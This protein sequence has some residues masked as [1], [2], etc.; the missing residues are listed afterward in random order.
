MNPGPIRVGVVCD[1]LEERWP[2]MDLVAEMILEHLAK[3]PAG[4]VV[5]ERI[6]PPWR[7]RFT[8]LPAVG[9]KGVARNA[10]RVF[11]RYLNYPRQLRTIAASGHYDLFHLVDHSYAQLLLAL[12]PGRAVV[13]CHD[14][15]TFR[16]L[17]EPENE[18]RPRWFRAL[19]QRTLTG[20]QNAAAVACDS[21]ATKS[22]ILRHGLLPEETLRV[23]YLSVHPECSHEPNPDHDRA[24]T[25]LLG[26]LDPD[27]P[28]EI[29]HVGSNI[30]RKRIDVLLNVFAGIRRAIPA[31]RL[32]KV[33]GRFTPEQQALAESL[34][35]VEAITIIPYFDP[36]SSSQRATLAAVYRRA[37]LAMQTSDAEGFGLPVA[38]AMACGTTV[39]AS[40]LPVLREVGGEA[41]AYEPVGE[42]VPWVESALSLLE[43]HRKHS[44]RWRVRRDAGINRAVRFAWT[45]HVD[46]LV[47]MYQDVI[48]GRPAFQVHQSSIAESLPYT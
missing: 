27:G 37:A 2:S 46:I 14:L 20:L 5:P 42:I 28:P 33:G 40:D 29:L 39:L 22:A 3:R 23:V 1:Y 43:E 9:A 24:A 41:V 18:P 21:E 11:N 25:D 17:L 15:D 6:R 36:K 44:D 30:P 45:T 8:K 35:I 12:P 10:D 16:C 34:G 48:A 7:E 4:E 32:V 47:K 26:P 13:T 19:A 31:A 38:E